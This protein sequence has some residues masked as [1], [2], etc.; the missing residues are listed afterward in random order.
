MTRCGMGGA[1]DAAV[2]LA[3][4]LDHPA[5]LLSQLL[6]LL[7]GVHLTDE[8][9][10]VGEGRVTG[11]HQGL[12]DHGGHVATGQGVLH[13]LQQPVADHA[14]RLGTEGVEGV[15]LGEA[16]VIGG[17]QGQDPTWGPFP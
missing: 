5:P 14:L 16:L 15:G 13:G 8:L 4:G 17:L 3:V 11:H 10:G 12:V 7:L 2:V 1:D 6:G 9:G